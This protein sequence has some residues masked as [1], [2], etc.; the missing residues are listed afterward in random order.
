M[1][2]QRVLMISVSAGS[3]HV[4]AAQAL[5]EATAKLNQI[6]VMHIDVMSY[7]SR[8]FRGVYSDFYRHLIHH[9]PSLWAYLYKKTDSAQQDDISSLLRRSIEQFCTKKLI[10][11]IHQF[12]PDHIICTHFLPAELLSRELEQARLSCPVWVQVTDFDLH[13]LWIQPRMRGYFAANQ[14]VAFKMRERGIA[15]EAVHVTGIP[16]SSVF[17]ERHDRLDCR[18][19]LGLQPQLPVA[20]ILNGGARIGTV[21]EIAQRLLSNHSALQVIAVAGNNTQRLL[22]LQQ[23]AREFPQRLVAIGFSDSI[24][25]LMAASDLV[26]TKPGGLTSSECLIMGL[27]MLLV[28]PIPGQE[29][30]NGDYLME[31]GAAL[32]AHDIVALDYK[33]G[34]CLA[35]PDTLLTM[36]NRMLSIARP[37]AAEQVMAHVLEV[38]HGAN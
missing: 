34:Q 8:G 37:H 22:E 32:K 5:V 13:N 24:Q 7:V 25:K 30:R 20:L 17:L 27:P 35:N 15:A 10:S 14:E 16:V 26:V 18:T 3:G 28:D 33:I 29:E 9:A 2:Q 31:Q 21:V 19:E 12:Q 11:K 23:L 4:R 38:N 6:E 1:H 36:R